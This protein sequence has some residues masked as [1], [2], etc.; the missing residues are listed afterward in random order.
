M[1]L[2]MVLYLIALVIATNTHAQDLRVQVN[3]K[4]KV[5]YVD[6]AGNE[7]IKC[8]FESALPFEN[9]YAIVLKSKKYGIIDTSG[10]V[11]LPLKYS[12]ITSWNDSLYLI[13][14]GKKQGLASKH[15]DVVLEAKYSFISAPN[16]HGKA[17]LA[18]GG[19]AMKEGNNT[20]MANAKYGI[21]DNK[22]NIL[23]EPKY[24]GLYE[25]SYDGTNIYPYYEGRRLRYSDHYITDTLVTDCS[26][27]GFSSNPFNIAKAGIIDGHGNVILKNGL[28]DHVMYP[29]SDMVRYY[30]FKKNK[31]LC[32]FH[33]LNEGK[34]LQVAE[35]DTQANNMNYWS[36]GD[37]I[38]NIAP[39]NGSSSWRF[40]DKAGN[41]LRSGYS[42]IKHSVS[43]NLWAAKKS[44]GMWEVFDEENNDVTPLSGFDDIIFPL[45]KDDD[46]IYTVVKEN[47]YG[48]IDKDGK[49]IVPFEYDAASS[50]MFNFVYV[51]KNGRYGVLTS[52]N[53]CLIPVEF[54]SIVM[55]TEYDMKHFWVMKEDS[56]FYHYNT[57]KKSIASVG[58][59]LVSNFKDGIALAQPTN[60]LFKDTPL[61]RALLFVPG[62]K[63]EDIDKIDFEKHTNALGYMISTDDRVIFDMPLSPLY[64]DAVIEEME[65]LGKSVLSKSEK[66]NILLK[67]TEKNRS[68]ELNTTISDEDWDY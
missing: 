57:E 33:D 3:K 36:H 66:K 49:I 14:D 50:N 55:P 20:Y 52:S 8:Q 63:K 42:L 38:G 19:K 4:G 22:G 1:K 45:N 60:V 6:E 26:Y 7:I 59:K 31:T 27:L 2:R 9:G 28:Y 24:R 43:S 18:L 40:I 48:C 35:F 44:D 53:Q 47:R 62:T 15:G 34:A 46:K 5:G 41:T 56:L 58:Y 29:Q 13:K 68:Y 23:I 11:V 16:C 64:K 54:S 65:R 32:G 39:V 37:F 17:L 21:I 10:N 30:I 67:V 12:S 51:I 61:N 25:F